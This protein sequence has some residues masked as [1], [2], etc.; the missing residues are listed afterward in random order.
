M[1]N[2][3]LNRNRL[4]KSESGFTLIEILIV[5]AILG[6]LVMVAAPTYQDSVRKSRRSDAMQG[7]ME[8]SARQARFYAQNSTYTTV[9]DADTGLHYGGTTSAEGYYTFAVM[10]GPSG[11]IATS[12]TLTATPIGSQADDVGCKALF[13][14]SRGERGASG[15]L[16]NE[17]W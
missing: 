3:Q 12:Y 4:K 1:W 5:L 6:I 8:L 11:S 14:T 17:C 2:S 7:L 16:G 10:A 9:V 15:V 13:M